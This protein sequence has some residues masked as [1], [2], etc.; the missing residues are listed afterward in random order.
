[1]SSMTSWFTLTEDLGWAN[2]LPAGAAELPFRYAHLGGLMSDQYRQCTRWTDQDM[3]TVDGHTVDT[4]P[5]FR[6]VDVAAFARW[7]TCRRC[8]P[9]P[10]VLLGK[11]L[12]GFDY[13][14]RRFLTFSNQD[15][16]RF[17]NFGGGLGTALSTL[18][19]AIED[20]PPGADLSVELTIDMVWFMARSAWI[21]Q[22]MDW[23]RASRLDSTNA[24][25]VMPIC[26][27]CIQMATRRIAMDKG[28]DQR[29][30]AAWRTSLSHA[31][32]DVQNDTALNRRIRAELALERARASAAAQGSS[33]FRPTTPL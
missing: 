31:T 18:C 1:V 23:D 24:F 12:F 15:W 10:G 11:A 22:W 14:D 21:L 6:Y 8:G 5:P 2:A 25:P 29:V 27:E 30:A 16:V 4:G 7:A 32:H 33:T 3:I 26:R 17:T 20:S 9:D 28:L 19:L 13:D